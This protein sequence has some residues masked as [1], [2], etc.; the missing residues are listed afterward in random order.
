MT[1]GNLSLEEI[2]RRNVNFKIKDLKID[3]PKDE[4][5]LDQL[6]QLQPHMT[7]RMRVTPE[8]SRDMTFTMRV[9]IEEDMTARLLGHPVESFPKVQPFEDI[10]KYVTQTARFAEQIAEALSKALKEKSGEKQ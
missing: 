2:I 9:K 8:V 1:F 10:T 6:E 5:I 7:L 4:R 3:D